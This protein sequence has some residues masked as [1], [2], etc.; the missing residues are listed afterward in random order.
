MKAHPKRRFLFVG[1]PLVLGVVVAVTVLATG[2]VSAA[3]GKAPPKAVAGQVTIYSETFLPYSR[4]GDD[5]AV[6]QFRYTDPGGTYGPGFFPNL[7][8]GPSGHDAFFNIPDLTIGDKAMSLVSAEVC[9]QF[10]NESGG[11]Y[12]DIL[13]GVQ[14]ADRNYTT[15]LVSL[16]E[17]DTEQTC[18]T[19]TL[20]P[21][22][23]LVDHPHLV[24]VLNMKLATGDDWVGVDGVT[25]TLQPTK[26]SDLPPGQ[27]WVTP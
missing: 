20:A 10:N 25:Y 9:L 12:L 26:K 13:F 23:A 16:T 3:P 6:A 14:D 18:H 15:T 27:G 1:L 22:V 8:H 4:P 19:L 2:P 17:T 11:S 5:G 21:P 7:F 24:L